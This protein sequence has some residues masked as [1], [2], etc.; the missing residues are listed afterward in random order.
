VD[1]YLE[2]LRGETLPEKLASLRQK[3]YQKAKNEPRFRFYSL[4]AHVYREDVLQTAWKLVKRNDGAAGIDGVK[5]QDVEMREG[6][7][8]RFLEEIKA[9]LIDRSYKPEPVRRVYIEKPQGGKRPLGIPTVKDRVVQAA[10]RLIVEPIFEAD[11]LQSSYGFRPGRSQHDALTEVKQHVSD[12]FREVY[13][14]DLKGYFDSIPHDKLIKCVEMRI[15]DQS[16]IKLI[17]M[18][19]EAAIVETDENGRKNSRRP[20]QGTPQGGVIS[21]LLSNIYLHWFDKV[22]QSDDGPARWANAKLVRFADDM[23]ILARY[24]GAR[25]GNFA[26]A[27]LEDWMGLRMNSEKTKV[28]KLTQE[29]SSL[30]F[31]GFT[32]R[33]DRDLKGRQHRYLNIMPSAKALKRARARVKELTASSRCFMPIVDIIEEINEYFASWK[34]YY[35]FGYPSKAFRSLDHYV[36]LRLIAHLRRRSQRPYEP[37]PEVSFYEHLSHLGLRSL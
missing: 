8:P 19:L 32:F 31:L 4:Y 5:L 33:Y 36:G 28:V 16:V 20:T 6:G 30:D 12:G 29:G 17:K 22:F 27:K 3:L 24:V 34:P 2:I 18:W 23:V 37:P 35:Q 21:P 15:S 13:D 1:E 11:F 14:I 10:V 9:S 26:Q 25:I 7:V